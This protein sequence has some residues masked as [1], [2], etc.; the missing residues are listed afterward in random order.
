M[1]GCGCNANITNVPGDEISGGGG[2][3]TGGPFTTLLV[4]TILDTSSGNTATID[5]VNPLTTATTL[6]ANVN[7]DVRTTA[8]PTFDRLL[9]TTNTTSPPILVNSTNATN[10]ANEIQFQRSGTYYGS[11]GVNNTTGDV[12]AVAGAGRPFQ[13]STNAVERIRIPSTGIPLDNTAASVLALQGTTLSS[14]ND[15]VDSAF[16]SANYVDIASPQSIVGQK[17]MSLPILINPTLK[18]GAGAPEITINTASATNGATLSIPP[19]ISGFFIMSAGAGQSISQV[20]TFT[21]NPVISA[22]TKSGNTI[23]I[24]AANT[25]LVGTNTIDTLINK[26]ISSSNN[27]IQI[28]SAGNVNINSLLD[29]DVRTTAGPTF[30]DLFVS[31][32]AYASRY[33]TALNAVATAIA[34][35]GAF[36][37]INS[38]AASAIVSNNITASGTTGIRFGGVTRYVHLSATISMDAASN[39]N[40]SAR[41]TLNGAA[42]PG[43]TQRGHSHSGG[44]GAIEITVASIAKLATGDVIDL[45]ITNLTNTNA[46]TV[47][48]WTINAVEML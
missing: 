37:A 32:Y 21:G 25:T 33:N 19:T 12:Y 10:V 36:V 6:A 34:V 30:N 2:G 38:T 29:Q 35:A 15:L 20:I 48:W 46:V 13:I 42:I 24:P 16:L 27:T 11:F 7:Q 41:M 1:S 14:R 4:D 40:L 44:V 8:T 3:G 39:V 5:G 22:I 45:Q 28:S 31:T 47:S 17:I 43:T 26:V 18:S 23:T 9:L